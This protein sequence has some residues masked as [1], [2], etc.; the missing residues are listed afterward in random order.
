[1]GEEELD[2]SELEKH[3]TRFPRH[4]DISEYD[5]FGMRYPIFPSRG[6]EFRSMVD[7]AIFQATN[8]I[9]AINK[10]YSNRVTGF[11]PKIVAGIQG[12]DPELW[13]TVILT[14]QN[15]G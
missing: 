3:F 6:D 14:K 5:G 15:D 7:R 9:F 10:E 11:I 1:M 8:N 13:V 4:S 2:F 12:G